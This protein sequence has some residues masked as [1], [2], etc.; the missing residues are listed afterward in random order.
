MNSEQH[1]R[2]IGNDIGTPLCTRVC[3]CVRCRALVENCAAVII[4]VEN[5]QFDP[6]DLDSFGTVPQVFAIVQPIETQGRTQYRIAFITRNNVKM[7]GPH[8]A[9][10]QVFEQSVVKNWLLTK[11]TLHSRSARCAFTA[12]SLRIPFAAASLC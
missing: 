6:K 9:H 3:V 10:D 1:R 5:G 7:K 12:L 11:C 8:L 2:L 4:F